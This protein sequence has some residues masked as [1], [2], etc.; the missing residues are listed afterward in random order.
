[1]RTPPGG[2]ELTGPTLGSG[3][4]PCDSLAFLDPITS[5]WKMYRGSSLPASKGSW[6]RWPSSGLMRSGSVFQRQPLVPRTFGTASGLL[7]TPLHSWLTARDVRSS[8]AAT[9]G[10]K[11]T[12]PD[13]LKGMTPEDLEWMMGFPI[14][15]TDLPSW[16]TPLF[17]E[18]LK[19]Y[20]EQ[21]RRSMQKYPT[22]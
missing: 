15:W 5:S 22:R 9:Y 18:S 8:S 20:Y 6:T 12:I 4:R 3:E 16:A 13:G 17:R 11:R 7:P 14:G 1:M 10:G 21:L 19:P 2:S